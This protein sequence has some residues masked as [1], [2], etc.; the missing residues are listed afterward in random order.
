MGSCPMRSPPKM[1]I[2]MD[3]TMPRCMSNKSVA[4]IAAVDMGTA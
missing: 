1:L 2:T 3:I 4:S